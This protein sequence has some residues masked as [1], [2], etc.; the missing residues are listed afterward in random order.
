MTR[1]DLQEVAVI[2]Q[3]SNIP[4]DVRRN[5]IDIEISQSDRKKTHPSPKHMVTIQHVDS[6]PGG[7]LESRE[8]AAGE[9][10][11][12][13]ARQVAKRMASERIE[14]EENDV[15]QHDERANSDAKLSVEVEGNNRVVPEKTEEYDADI[16]EIPMDVL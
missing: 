1:V 13:S 10:V 9:T 11:E 4:E 16:K 12:P 5:H 15:R 8:S 2:S 14:R 6:F 7:V 3:D